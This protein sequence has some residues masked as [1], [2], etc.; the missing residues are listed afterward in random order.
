M[1]ENSRQRVIHIPIAVAVI[2]LSLQVAGAVVG[3]WHRWVWALA[4]PIMLS[5]MTTPLLGTER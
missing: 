2:F 4:G 3:G 5:N 1:C